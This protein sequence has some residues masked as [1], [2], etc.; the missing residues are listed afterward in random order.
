MVRNAKRRHI[1]TN[2]NSAL[3][4]ADVW[5]F[6]GSLGIGK[7]KKTSLPNILSQMKR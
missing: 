4:P 5:H 3:A 6:L 7:A 1:L 2:I